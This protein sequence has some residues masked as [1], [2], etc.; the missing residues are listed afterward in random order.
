[1]V[2]ISCWQSPI[3]I[4]RHCYYFLLW[5]MI[6]GFPC[7][8]SIFGCLHPMQMMYI[9]I[10]ITHRLNT[11]I[12]FFKTYIETTHGFEFLWVRNLPYMW[13]QNM[14]NTS[15]IF[16]L[17]DDGL[18]MKNFVFS[19]LELVQLIYPFMLQHYQLPK[20][21]DYSQLFYVLFCHFVNENHKITHMS[22]MKQ[23]LSPT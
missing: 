5:L 13:V 6:H 23:R 7:C 22:K 15:I 14:L 16:L 21:V 10:P 11:Q 19:Y 9:S 1:M 12:Q 2:A 3:A 4:E 18:N 8:C 20:Q 17:S